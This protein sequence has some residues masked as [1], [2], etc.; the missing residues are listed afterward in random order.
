MATSP[1]KSPFLFDQKK[2]QSQKRYMQPRFGGWIGYVIKRLCCNFS[3]IMPSAQQCGA[4]TSTARNMQIDLDGLYGAERNKITISSKLTGQ[5]DLLV[6]NAVA[7]HQK[8]LWS[9]PYQKR[10]EGS[11]KSQPSTYLQSKDKEKIYKNL[12][13]PKNATRTTSMSPTRRSVNRQRSL[14]VTLSA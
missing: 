11:K 4:L 5:L 6:Q 8:K 3:L 13:A 10:L 1:R 9:S 12:Q 2:N 7:L 14:R